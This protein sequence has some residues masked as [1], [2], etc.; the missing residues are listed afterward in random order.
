MAAKY[1]LEPAKFFSTVKATIFDAK[2][3]QEELI[4]FL[5]VANRYNLDPFCGEVFAFR[6]QGGGVQAVVGVD[7]WSAI[8][9]NH[10]QMDGM[11]FEDRLNDDGDLVAVTCRIYRKDRS[12]PVTCTEYMVECKRRTGP[13]GQWP[14]RM[15]RHK[16]TIQCARLAFGLTG[17]IDPDEAE[18]FEAAGVGKAGVNVAESPLNALLDKMPASKPAEPEEH[19]EADAEFVDDTEPVEAP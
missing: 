3:T 17:I 7:G 18:R 13:W 5:T 9:N 14:R 16:A 11:E 8:I 10:P 19:Y 1:S 15:L 12:H 6:K 2:A 4:A